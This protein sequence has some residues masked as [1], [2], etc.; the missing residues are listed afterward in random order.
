M[1]AVRKP[2]HK[3]QEQHKFYMQD[4]DGETVAECYTYMSKEIRWFSGLWV[5]KDYRN[6]GIATQMIEKMLLQYGEYDDIYLRVEPFIDMPMDE[7]QL[8][9]FYSGFGF[10]AIPEVP[11]VMKRDATG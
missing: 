10:Y 6:Q 4:D 2:T 3:I 1:T 8:E 7:D 9:K 11:G 5:K